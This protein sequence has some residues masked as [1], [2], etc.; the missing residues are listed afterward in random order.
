[1]R[2]VSFVS[3]TLVACVG[4][5]LG[6]AALPA[7]AVSV[8]RLTP[9]SELFSSGQPAPVIARFLPGQRFDLQATVFPDA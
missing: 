9:P 3:R 5:A 1:M 6:V 7:G 2:S 8:S 4:A